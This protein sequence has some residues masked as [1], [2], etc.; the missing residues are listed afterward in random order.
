MD[1]ALV[2]P[3]NV[4]VRK[5]AGLPHMGTDASRFSGS[6]SHGNAIGGS[7]VPSGTDVRLEASLLLPTHFS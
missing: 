7:A 2:R 4:V 6:F 1:I 5:K 3:E